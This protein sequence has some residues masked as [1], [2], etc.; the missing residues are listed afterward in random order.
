MYLCKLQKCVVSAKANLQPN[1]QKR[2][3]M[4]YKKIILVV[5]LALACFS[6]QNANALTE[7]KVKKTETQTASPNVYWTDGYGRVSYTTNSI[8]SPVVKIA[9]KEFAGDMKAVTGFEA[10]EKSSAPIQIYQLDQ[11]TNKEFSAVEKLGAPLHLIITA[12]DAFYIGTRKGKL[13]VIGS[14]ARGTAYAI[15]KLSE[16]AGVAPLMAWNDLQPAQRK[17]LYTPVDQQ[18]IEVPRIEFRGLALNN[19]QWMKP[20]NYSRIARLMLRLRANTLWQVDGK[21]EAAYNK[22]VVD[23]FDICVA[24]NYKV[25]EF[26]GKKHKKKHRKTIE[27]VKLVCSDAQMEMSNLSPGLLLEMLNSKD[28]LESKNAQHGKSHR[29]EA[30]NDEDCAWIANVTNPKQ[31]TFQLAM[32][33]NLAWNKNAL[34]AGCTTYIQNAL[35][36]FFG[37]VTGRKIMPLMEEYYRL[38]SIRHSAYMAMPYGDTEFHSGEF[39]NELERFLYRYDLLK[40]KTESIERMLPQNQK[41]GFFEVVKYPIFLAAFVAEKELEAQEAR[42][43]ARPGLF[44]K[45]DEAKAAAAVSID[46]YNNLKQLNAYYSRIRNGKWKDFILTNDA[47][48]QAPQIPG[49]LP[50]TDIKRLKADAFDRNNDLKPLSVVTSDIIAKNA[51][52][53]S[54]ATESP[55]AQAA[56]RGAEKITVRPLLGHSGKAVKLPKGASL[57]YDF[58]SEMS[59]DARF[60]IA[61]VPCFL[62]AVKDMRVSVSIDRAEPVICQLKEV[63]NSKDWKFD[64]WRGQ[65]L[66]SFYVTLPGG[67]HNVTIK[68]LDD[69]VMID[70]WVLD[71]DVD[72]EYYVFPVAK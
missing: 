46:A 34:K 13:I 8:L 71:Y 4:K 53:W 68:A 50:A 33:M 18:W 14:N 37:A 38:T 64:L 57:S 45:D 35:N 41:D 10:K 15:M 29:S 40:A 6:S 69:N 67:S 31:S 61:V 59:G 30:H 11:L 25:T 44:N 52:E 22:A 3:K 39:G 72:R 28:Y 43:I 58:Y 56:V 42:H 21:H 24:E 7:T 16:L 2:I 47:E 60:T 1:R 48:M 62:N 66:K 65:T 49:T 12:K 20:Q 23:S 5:A 27:N 70:Q 51:W 9:L 32:M 55:L 54:K 19:S 26:V 36:S 63:Y 17:S